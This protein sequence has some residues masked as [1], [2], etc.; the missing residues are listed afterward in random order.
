[1][2][3]AR[4]P[5][6]AAQ[7]PTELDFIER[8]ARGQRPAEAKEGAVLLAFD[9][10]EAVTVLGLRL[11][12]SVDSVVAVRAAGS[13]QELHHRGITVEREERIAIGLPPAAQYKAFG[14]D[15]EFA[16]EAAGRT[17]R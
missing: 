6:N 13:R 2:S 10:P 9:R 16:H 17:A 14:F 8:F 4:T 1:M 11:D 15:L 12:H 7:A 3:I 5:G